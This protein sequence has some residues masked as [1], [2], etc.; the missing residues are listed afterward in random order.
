MTGL[1]LMGIVF[2]VSIASAIL[3]IFIWLIGSTWR[4]NRDIDEL[5]VRVRFIENA[6]LT[7]NPF[8]KEENKNGRQS[9]RKPNRRTR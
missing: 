8:K 2:S 9:I 5:L 7:S 3:Y 4:N 6:L 1:E